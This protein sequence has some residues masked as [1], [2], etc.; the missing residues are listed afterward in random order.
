V[1]ETLETIASV[2]GARMVAG[3]PRQRVRTIAVDPSEAKEGALF[4]T[5]DPRSRDVKIAWS[6]GAIVFAD[7]VPGRV[8]G[9]LLLARDVTSALQRLATAHLARAPCSTVGITGSVGKTTIKEMT[10]AVLGCMRAVHKTPLNRNGQLGVPMT[11]LDRPPG[12]EVLV[13]EMGISLPGEMSRLVSIAPPSIAVLARL[14]PVHSANFASFRGLVREKRR[15]LVGAKG[16]PPRCAVVH[17]ESM[18]LVVPLPSR[19]ITYGLSPGA[20]IFGSDLE[21]RRDPD[22]PGAVFT[23]RGIAARPLRV[24]LPLFGRAMVEDALA[25]LAVGSALGLAATDMIAAL[26]SLALDVPMRQ[27]WRTAG[28]VTVIDDTYNAAPA[29]MLAGLEVLREAFVPGCRIAV[30]GDMLELGKGSSELHRALREPVERSCDRLLTIGR[31]MRCLHEAAGMAGLWTEHF[32]DLEQLATRLG[33]IVRPGDAVL[34][35]ASRGI[36]LERAVEMFER[37]LRGSA[38]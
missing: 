4:I 30:L 3:E 16:A 17:V 2:A 18:P 28:G 25:A 27:A 26:E 20:E 37:E 36:R 14:S 31:K 7:G 11:V 13:L 23:V 21:L 15:L 5:F 29:S 19:A 34:F 8:G 24:R 38:L 33:R 32:D 22:R 1:N 6:R 10:A 9:P 35:K 12:T